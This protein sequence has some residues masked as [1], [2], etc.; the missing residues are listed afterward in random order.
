MRVSV[1]GMGK[2][3]SALADALL[4]SGHS[5]TVWNRSAE[6][7]HAAER[8]GARIAASV[9]EAVEA[10]DVAVICLA[11]DA[12]VAATIVRDEV[13]VSLAGKTILQLSQST[14]A[15]SDQF[16][17]WALAHGIGYLDGSIMG[18]PSDIRAGNC[19]IVYSGAALLFEKTADVLHSLGTKPR[20]VGTVPSLASIFDKAFFS[21]YYSHLAGLF[22]G[23]A[24]CRAAGAPLD[25]YFELMIGGWHWQGPD[26]AFADMIISSD[27]TAEEATLDVHAHAFE[28]VSPLCDA[29]GV[30]TDLPDAIVSAMR[31][32][33]ARGHGDDEIATMVEVFQQ[34][35]G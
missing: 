12:A 18:L 1:F 29:L 15:Q 2:M 27:Y 22:H 35:Q 3:G 32:A 34:A 20:L 25:I 14:P 8:G 19:M 13:A 11:D 7:C 33:I 16:S 30:G 24:M 26:A 10:C 5:V 6:K 21:A 17:E 4:G 31:L 28:Q 9:V 23:A